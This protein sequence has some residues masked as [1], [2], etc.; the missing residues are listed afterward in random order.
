VQACEKGEALHCPND[1]S[2]PGSCPL[3]CA[4]TAFICKELRQTYYACASAAVFEC[5]SSGKPVA[6]ACND[7]S[8][9]Y[10]LC[11]IGGLL[12]AATK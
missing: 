12:D 5:D 6:P 8:R 9:D 10:G 4:F 11:V 3:G 7:Q 1:D 2:T